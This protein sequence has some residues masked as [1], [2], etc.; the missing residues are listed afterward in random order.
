M[1]KDMFAAARAANPQATLLINDY[2]IEPKYKDLL[3]LLRNNGKPIFDVIGIQSHMHDGVWSSQKIWDI[4]QEYAFFGIP[5]H[6]TE[7]TI[8]SSKR[9]GPGE[10]WGPTDPSL[11]EKQA[12]EAERFYATLFGH[13]AVEAITWWDFTDQGAW[14]G[15]AAGFLRKDLSPKP[16]YTTLRKLI[17]EDWCSKTHLQTDHNGIARLHAFY[18]DYR[19]TSMRNNTSASRFISHDR[20]IRENKAELKLEEIN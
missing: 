4:C 16:I 3:E 8:V 14:Q 11:E 1:V 9:L 5:L 18:G 2:R 7:T 20:R 15:A 6:F 12:K 10:N 13:P 19:I 17:R